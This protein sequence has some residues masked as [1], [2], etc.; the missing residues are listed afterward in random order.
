VIIFR[1]SKGVI[2]ADPNWFGPRLK[3]LRKEKG[4]ERQEDLATA[5]GL[6]KAGI[7]NIEQG[8]TLPS[9]DTV[10]KLCA[11]LGVKADAFMVEPSSLESHAPGR[12]R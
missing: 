1:I 3:E 11:A 8:R 9:W 10:I 5:A 6:A 7:A 12:V 2:M 4:F